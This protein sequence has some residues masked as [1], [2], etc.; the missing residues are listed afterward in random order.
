MGA[1]YRLSFPNGKA[2]I[3]VTVRTA[4]RRFDEH[5]RSSVSGRYDY[6][7][8][9]AIRKY[10]RDAIKMETLA[11]ADAYEYLLDLEQKAIAAFGTHRPGGYNET[12]GGK[13]MAGF[14]FS[15]ESRARMA[16]AGRRRA[17][18]SEETR[19][20]LRQAMVGREPVKAPILTKEENERRG[21]ER[22]I[23]GAPISSNKSGVPGVS[24]HKHGR[25]WQ[26][27]F[28]SKGRQFYIGLFDDF[29]AAVDARVQAVADHIGGASCR[30]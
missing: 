5:V 13:G 24:W 8:N 29:A 25:K 3:G 27:K 26:V 18:I 6:A 10:G 14:K 7:I 19:L 30:A 16:D 12:V 28:K 9:R 17:P 11:I 20:K 22:L 23:R 1:L 21:L 4:E 2:Y 15:A